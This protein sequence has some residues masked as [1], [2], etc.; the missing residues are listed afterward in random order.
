M[1]AKNIFIVALAVANSLVVGF[2]FLKIGS[3]YIV[4]RVSDLLVTTH[5]YQLSQVP[6]VGSVSLAR[7]CDTL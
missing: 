2:V 6:R 7:Q 3:K 5:V 4:P 1:G